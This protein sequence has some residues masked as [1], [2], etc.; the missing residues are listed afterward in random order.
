MCPPSSALAEDVSHPASLLAP[1]SSPLARIPRCWPRRQH[2][3]AGSRPAAARR[4]PTN[5]RA[6]RAAA[7]AAA[8]ALSTQPPP[9]PRRR[10]PPPPSLAAHPTSSAPAT[11]LAAASSPPPGLHPQRGSSARAAR[12][13]RHH[14]VRPPCVRGIRIPKYRRFGI[15]K[16]GFL[17]IFVKRPLKTCL[18]DQFSLL[19]T[20]MVS[21]F[22][23][24]KYFCTAGDE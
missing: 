10:L 4:G 16:I 21:D 3:Q 14:C 1:S 12:P 18:L 19:I 23:R 13:P 17:Q 11:H 6:A 2:L 5:R 8:A 24:D 9:P 15:R 22:A 7:A 20:N